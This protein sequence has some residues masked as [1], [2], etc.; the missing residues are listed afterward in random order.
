MQMVPLQYKSIQYI[1][2]LGHLQF[3]GIYF[4]SGFSLTKCSE[5]LYSLMCFH[6]FHNEICSRSY[7]TSSMMLRIAFW[8]F[9]C[10]SG[11]GGGVLF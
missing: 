11:G 4:Y 2:Y 8:Q 10:A 1:S 5:I 9:F 6:F 7:C 3:T